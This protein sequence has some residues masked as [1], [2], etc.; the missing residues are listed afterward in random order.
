[1]A[2][3]EAIYL[4]PAARLPV[5]EVP[6]ATAI[7]GQGLEGDHAGGGR[8]QVTIL[9]REAWR[10]ACA[11]FGRPVDPSVRRAN[12]L[13]EGI[14]LASTIG[15]TL[16]IGSVTFEI[17][18]ETRPCELMDDDGRVGLYRSLRPE[19]RGGVH[20]IVRVGGTLR[21]GDAVEV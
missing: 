3:L 2:R 15:T 6:R 11:A 18:G 5:R 20:G 10:D 17:V 12:L 13:V 14:D 4:R 1:M 21:V 19:R 7:A 16:R 8:R 9:S